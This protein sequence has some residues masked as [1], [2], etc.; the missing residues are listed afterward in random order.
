MQDGCLPQVRNGFEGAIA[1][2][3]RRLSNKKESLDT[4][5]F[6][7]P[8]RLFEAANNAQSVFRASGLYMYPW[9]VPVG[10][11]VYPES[12]LSYLYQH[13]VM[14]PA[15]WPIAD[16]AVADAM[17]V[18][19]P[20]FEALLYVSSRKK[21]ILSNV[22]LR[23]M[24][25]VHDAFHRALATF[26]K[27]AID[28]GCW[29]VWRATYYTRFAEVESTVTRRVKRVLYDA[30]PPVPRVP[31]TKGTS[32]QEMRRKAEHHM[33]VVEQKA[34]ERQRQRKFLA[35]RE[36]QVVR[37]ITP[38]TDQD[39]LLKGILHRAAADTME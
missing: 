35:N 3:I 4:V 28:G 13:W 2:L 12:A 15:Q 31:F 21:Y 37:G 10:A 34:R 36:R 30:L 20:L 24:H 16:G 33:R 29:T 17:M 6:L 11:S 18:V 27:R 39:E 9:H 38:Y 14:A 32:A 23:D 25:N 5:E 8:H 1:H 26:H 7:L 19:K 22:V